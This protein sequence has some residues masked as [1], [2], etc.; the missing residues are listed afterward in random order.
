MRE[1]PRWA[2]QLAHE[3]GAKIIVQRSDNDEWEQ[4]A[5][6]PDQNLTAGYR[7]RIANKTADGLRLDE[8]LEQAEWDIDNIDYSDSKH[9]SE[10]SVED[11]YELLFRVCSYPNAIM[12][13]QLLKQASKMRPMTAQEI[14]MLPRG[15]GFSYDFGLFIY[16][17]VVMEDMSI[18]TI[19]KNDVSD[20]N[21][22]ILPNE[23]E[24]RK[25][26]AEA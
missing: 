7:Y 10:R 21:G 5:C 12:N 24:L 8:L 15:T 16:N 19:D 11:C 2:I 13:I 25:F 4:T 26:E 1:I 22:Y 20:F 3:N 9:C 18:I 23:T 17:P 6:N 14:A